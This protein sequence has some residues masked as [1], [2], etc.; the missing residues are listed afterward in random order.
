MFRISRR[1]SAVVLA[2]GICTGA[3]AQIALSS[4]FDIA[5]EADAD[6]NAP[7]VAFDSFSAFQFGTL[8]PYS[9]SLLVTDTV[10]GAGY[11]TTTSSAA[12]TWTSSGAGTVTF[13]NMGWTRDS[14][15]MHEAKMNN[16]LAGMDVWSYTF[17]AT[18]DG[19]FSLNY[20]VSYVGF[21]FGLLGIVIHWSGPGGDLDL[22]N[23][24]DP[25][26]N[27]TFV[28]ELTNGSTY[29]IGI[30][31]KGNIFASAGQELSEGHLNG[32]FSWEVS[33]VPEPAT[34]AGLLIG[35]LGLLLRP[36]RTR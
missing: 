5:V 22:E 15:N 21:G 12:A 34:M 29:T 11:V 35:G 26:A 36:R 4:T 31:N 1:L 3:S 13:R 6:Q 2:A 16:F 8:N 18:Q 27:G 32:D 10:P 14:L 30:Q 23:A 24:S 7:G 17:E 25:T 20:N 33:P 9:H 28:R 19:F